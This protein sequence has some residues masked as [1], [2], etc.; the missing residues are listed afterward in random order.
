MKETKEPIERHA[1]NIIGFNGSETY[2]LGG[3]GV[4]VEI[5]PKNLLLEF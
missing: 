4:L 2:P 1:S 5:T 3:R